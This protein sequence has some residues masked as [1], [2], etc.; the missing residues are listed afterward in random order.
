MKKYMHYKFHIKLYHSLIDMG[1]H[2]IHI[3]R[4][5]NCLPKCLAVKI[6]KD[7]NMYQK[8]RNEISSYLLH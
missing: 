5:S 8:V 3:Q 2:K 7:I 4:D 1:F 6:Y